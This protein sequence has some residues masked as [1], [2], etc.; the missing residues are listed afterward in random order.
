MDAAVP[1][2]VRDAVLLLALGAGALVVSLVAAQGLYRLQGPPAAVP[3]QAPASLAAMA[4]DLFYLIILAGVW[5]LVVRRY[6][7]TWASLGLRL[8]ERSTLAPMLVLFAGLAAGCVAVTAGMIWALDAIGLPAR[9][10]PLT[11]VPAITDPLFVVAVLGSVI[12]TPVAEEVLFRG[13]LYQSLRKNMG[14]VLGIASSAI[15][16]AALHLQPEVVPE[17]LV[18][19]I[20]LA[21]AFERTRSLYPSMLMHATYNGVIILLALHVV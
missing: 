14:V 10:L 1:W 21:V 18:L 2:R 9:I 13:V 6:G 16:F 19:G 15:L 20:M 12:L 11:T 7:T 5:L 8:P 17:L 4:I 3:A